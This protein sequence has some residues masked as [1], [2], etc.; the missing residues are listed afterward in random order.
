M[1]KEGK[2]KQ[3][4][5]KTIDSHEKDLQE[6]K[7]KTIDEIEELSA[8]LIVASEDIKQKTDYNV[9]RQSITELKN[10]ISVLKISAEQ[11][12]PNYSQSQTN[13][14]GCSEKKEK[15][16]VQ[17]QISRVRVISGQGVGV[18]MNKL[19]LIFAV[20]ALDMCGIVPGL[21]SYMTVDKRS[22]WVPVYS[23]IG[24]FC[25]ECDSQ[26]NIPLTIEVM[27]TGGMAEL[28]PELGSTNSSI[29]LNCKCEI[30]SVITSVSLS[31]GGGEL[32]RNAVVEV[33]VSAKRIE[34][35]CC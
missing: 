23:P 2:S 1:E 20:R 9:L 4:L 16:C 34:S 15:C 31:G 21:T 33:E 14:C 13:K 30:S 12:I 18:D 19:E 10:A 32:T 28:R 35:G 6:T 5:Q 7:S 26:I 17:L 24:K 11:S 27:D 8:K 25:V 3:I 22:G 29:Q